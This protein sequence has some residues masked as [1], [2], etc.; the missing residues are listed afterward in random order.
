MARRV[1]L[2]LVLMTLVGLG[3]ADP[4]GAQSGSSSDAD[5]IRDWSKRLIEHYDK[6]GDMMLQ[7]DERIALRGKPAGADLNND[8]VITLNEL[9]THLSSDT[10]TRRPSS[11]PNTPRRRSAGS[12]DSPHPARAPATDRRPSRSAPQRRSESAEANESKASDAAAKKVSPP[13]RESRRKAGD[14]QRKSYRFKSPVERLPAGLP[15]WFRSRDA[16]RDGQVAM[17]EYSRTWTDRTA[18][19]FRRLDLNNDGF[20]TPKECLNGR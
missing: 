18:E 19:E 2:L 10:N 20:V 17:S 16:N 9:V 12:Q 13:S 4:A 3:C 5:R 15:S 7:A 14:D 1:G 11:E 6:N 8:D